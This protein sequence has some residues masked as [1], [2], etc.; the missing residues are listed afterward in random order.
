MLMANLPVARIRGK[1]C[2]RLPPQNS[3]SGGDSDT[4]ATD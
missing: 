4:E 1:L 3:T 2:D